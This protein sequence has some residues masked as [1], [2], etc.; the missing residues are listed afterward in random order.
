MD[1]TY[2]QLEIPFR[3]SLFVLSTVVSKSAGAVILDVGVKGLGS[4]QNL[5]V[6]LDESEKAITGRIWNLD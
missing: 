3:N 6:I 2:N 5:P 1:S 4:D